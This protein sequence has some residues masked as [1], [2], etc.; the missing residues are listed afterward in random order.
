MI[1]Q[2]LETMNMTLSEGCLGSGNDEER[3]EM[4]YVMR[5]AE[6]VNH[7]IF[8]RKL[9]SVGVPLEHASFSVVSTNLS[10]VLTYICVGVLLE[11]EQH[12]FVLYEHCGFKMIGGSAC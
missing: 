12:C 6:S 11:S 7:Q 3:S 9:R 1:A 2:N 5:I 4:R 8:E 10:D